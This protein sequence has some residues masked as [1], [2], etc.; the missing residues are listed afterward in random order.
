MYFIDTHNCYRQ[1]LIY[2]KLN[3]M[4]RQ[5]NNAHDVKK[6]L[7]EALR[8]SLDGFGSES[9]HPTILTA[10]QLVKR[11]LDF[12]IILPKLENLQTSGSKN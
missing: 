5:V 2:L 1:A 4:Q 6:P 10:K 12:Q 8:I 7:M 11:N 3:M 9:Q